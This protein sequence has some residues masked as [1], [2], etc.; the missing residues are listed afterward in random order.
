MDISLKDIN[1]YTFATVTNSSGLSLEVCEQG[2]SIYEIRYLGKPMNIVE[3]SREGFLKSTNYYGRSVG[4]MAG[5]LDEGNLPFKNE[6]L[7]I[8]TNEGKNTLHGGK[9]NLS[10]QKWRLEVTDRDDITSLNFSILSPKGEN[11]FPGNLFIGVTYT[12]DKKEPIFRME[13]TYVVDED[14]P[15]NLT[16]HTFFN[17]GG[18][19]TV[20]KQTLQI[21]AVGVEKYRKDLI[22]L[23]F[24][25]LYEAVDFRNS[26]AIGKD[27]NDPL[28]YTTRTKGYDHAFNI[29]PHHIEVPLVRMES[30]KFGMILKSTCPALQFY[31]ENYPDEKL[32][33][34]TLYRDALH[35]GA[36]LEP[37]EAPLDFGSMLKEKGK[38]Y[39]LQNVYEFYQLEEK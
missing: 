30:D 18:E 35:A 6:I 10:F 12:L 34:N 8:D 1:G 38:R 15:I 14:C 2:A 28:L 29:G 27:I 4:R 31:S 21:P 37:V 7:H 11:G 19:E 5:R 33:L 25:P 3:A 26:K 39:S 17:L 23:G 9:N 24:E 13:M 16:N 32:M 20:E 22:P 36:A